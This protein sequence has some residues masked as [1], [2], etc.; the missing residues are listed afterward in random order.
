VDDVVEVGHRLTFSD[1]DLLAG[2]VVVTTAAGH[3]YHLEADASAGGGFMA[4]AGYGGGHGVRRGR[5]YLDHEVHRL[6]GPVSPRTLATSLTDRLCA[7]RWGAV[8][9]T[10]ILEFALTR[11]ESYRYRPTLR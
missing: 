4:G 6:D 9:G 3:V 5:G 10:G 8:P 11:S 2:T 7:F 1:L